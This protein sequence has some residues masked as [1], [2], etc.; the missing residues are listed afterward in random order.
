MHDVAYGDEG[1]KGGWGGRRV[2]VAH[3]YLVG[4]PILGG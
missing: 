2:G 4:I 3:H 1:A